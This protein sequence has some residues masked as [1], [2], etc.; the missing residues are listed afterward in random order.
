MQPETPSNAI[1]G[2]PQAEAALTVYFDGA[3]PV[4]SREIAAYRSQAG[5]DQC[6]W[7]DASV[8]P[9]AAL[10][11]GLSREAALARFHVRRADGVLVDGMS[12]FVALWRAL[13]RFAWLGRLASIGPVP[14]LLEMVYR[15]FLIV[16]PLWQST[17]PAVT[18]K[19]PS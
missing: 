17:R 10:G 9:D 18:S 8:C 14:R 6:I 19:D 15:V 13:P 16:R 1:V 7:V 11:A 5:A 2:S 4:C 12:G 3:C